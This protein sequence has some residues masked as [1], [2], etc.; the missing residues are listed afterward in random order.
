MASSA[1]LAYD[2][3]RF[4]SRPLIHRLMDWALQHSDNNKSAAARLLKT[5]R[6]LFY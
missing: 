3:F 5:S 1:S 4:V 2:F 6:K